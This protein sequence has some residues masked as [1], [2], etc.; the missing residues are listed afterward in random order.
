MT[1]DGKYKDHTNVTM[2]PSRF[3]LKKYFAF[4]PLPY[5]TLLTDIDAVVSTHLD[6]PE[7]FAALLERTAVERIVVSP[8]EK[9]RRQ[10]VG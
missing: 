1:V 4:S 10:L 8:D 5:Q 3:W 2:F 7:D 6:L 9:K